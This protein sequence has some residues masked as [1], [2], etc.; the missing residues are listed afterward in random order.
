[1]AT[2]YP[3]PS[4]SWKAQLKSRIDENLEKLLGDAKESYEQKIAQTPIHDSFSRRKLFMEYLQTTDGLKAFAVDEYEYALERERQEMRWYTE[5][6]PQQDED[7]LRELEALKQEQFALLNAIHAGTESHV[8]TEPREPSTQATLEPKSPS[9]P[10]ETPASVPLPRRSPLLL[11]ESESDPDHRPPP[12]CSSSASQQPAS[13]PDTNPYAL[14][15][16]FTPLS[17]LFEPTSLDG[18]DVSELSES[19]FSDVDSES[20]SPPSTPP[21]SSASCQHTPA[22]VHADDEGARLK[23][24][25]QARQ[26]EEFHRRAEEIRAKQ[27]AKEN[28]KLDE[29]VSNND[30]P[31]YSSASSTSSQ[32]GASAST[33]TSTTSSSCP[34]PHLAALDQDAL[35]P[36][37]IAPISD[38][39]LVRLFIFHDQQWDRITS[40]HSLQWSDFPWPVLNFIGPRSEREITV[41]SVSEYIL[42][43]LQVQNADG[44]DEEGRLR[45][46]EMVKEQIRK[47][48]PDRFESRFLG[49]VP[50]ARGERMRVRR[51]A[52]LVVRYLTELLGRVNDIRIGDY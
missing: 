46:K 48:H 49:K 51:G 11:S 20:E 7:E 4:D 23:A 21:V 13:Q 8:H 38:E 37:V 9:R 25:Q 28:Q 18:D 15:T 32:S 41:D 16:N 17:P 31:F 50:E 52:G 27:R 3:E 22:K 29:W 39:D 36:F 40:F 19:E 45:R 44:Y 5:G 35:E 10:V 26:Q 14:F 24:E 33:S 30:T 42:S 12:R 43:A 34:S 47:W 1:M 6:V 2:E